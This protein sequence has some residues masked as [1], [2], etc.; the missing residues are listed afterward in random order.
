MQ[1]VQPINKSYT[2][3]SATP[4]VITDVQD[5]KNPAIVI[6]VGAGNTVTVEYS[7]TPGIQ[8]GATPTWIAW[9]KGPV[10]VNTGDVYL[11]TMQ[12]LRVTRTVGASAVTVEINV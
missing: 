10:T 12:A 5:L 11:G 8:G 9:D 2:F 7:L 1:A 4:F 6:N 3:N